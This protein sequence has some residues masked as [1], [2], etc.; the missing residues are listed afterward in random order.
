MS[1]ALC[2]GFLLAAVAFWFYRRSERQ[3]EESR[4]L[5][6]ELKAALRERDAEQ[7]FNYNV[8]QPKLEEQRRHIEKIE[9][10]NERLNEVL[11]HRDKRIEELENENKK[12]DG[13]L[14]E[15]KQNFRRY[16]LAEQNRQPAPVSL[17]TPTSA[18]RGL[19]GILGLASTPNAASP[20]Y[21][22]PAGSAA[23]VLRT[24]VFTFG[25]LSSPSTQGAQVEDDEASFSRAGPQGGHGGQ[26]SE[27]LQQAR[28]DVTQ[29]EAEAVGLREE[30][31]Q[32]LQAAAGHE[33]EVYNIREELQ[34]AR[35]AAAGIETELR[36]AQQAVMGLE[37]ERTNF[38]GK[39]RHAQ[40]AVAGYEA[41]TKNL[42]EELQHAQDTVAQLEA[43]AKSLREELQQARRNTSQ[44]EAEVLDLQQQLEAAVQQAK[45][46]TW[47]AEQV[48]EVVETAAAAI[49]EAEGAKEDLVDHKMS[50]ELQELH[51]QCVQLKVLYRGAATDV[52]SLALGGPFSSTCAHLFAQAARWQIIGGRRY[53]FPPSDASCFVHGVVSAKVE[54]LSTRNKSLQQDAKAARAEAEDLSQRN[55]SLQCHVEEVLA[56]AEDM[57]QRNK[58]LQK[59]AEKAQ[60]SIVRMLY[61][62]ID[63]DQ[64]L[65]AC[66][67]QQSEL[68]CLRSQLV[69]SRTEKESAAQVLQLTADQVD[70]ERER[71]CSLSAD[72]ERAK[73][74]VESIHQRMSTLESGWLFSGLGGSF[75]EVLRFLEQLEDFVVERNDR[76]VAL[77]A[78]AAELSQ[79]FDK[80]AEECSRLGQ[81]AA[82]LAA[83]RSA[84]L[85]DA[86]RLTGL[87]KELEAERMAAISA[88]EATRLERDDLA[89]VRESL[90]R[91]VADLQLHCESAGDEIA[92]AESRVAQLQEQLAAVESRAA[93]LQ[94]KLEASDSRCAELSGQVRQ[95]LE[96]PEEVDAVMVGLMNEVERDAEMHALSQE[97]DELRGALEAANA[98]K[99]RLQ[100]QV[101]DA[102]TQSWT[103]V[104]APPPDGSDL[105]E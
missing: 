95:L 74:V 90:S 24:P 26:S 27:L 45:S 15:K 1:A 94:A 65:E 63:R 40:Q 82:E 11:T 89:R 100:G 22:L 19:T 47:A 79:D 35:Q 9:R 105:N 97:A 2:A 53:F 61:E 20:G 54:E 75:E 51:E 46:A 43:D 28:P 16:M 92:A 5:Q 18:T 39:L 13:L 66:A 3:A 36:Q 68:D 29:L 88:L 56:E 31:Q 71:A 7:H 50:L 25:S 104:V 96:A 6:S 87:C 21:R 64:L 12:L 67:K 30:L 91:K 103:L 17:L 98:E 52:V 70:C 41:E 86:V 8:T 81:R 69:T 58:N 37:A 34:Q 44:L 32:A 93:Q 72:M 55:R 76:C 62:G 23:K 48:A 33:A 78:Q 101:A 80:V 60:A 57:S 84:L 49:Q 83:K 59:D 99:E 10:I 73:Q 4:R 102:N 85:S 42:R 14:R 77:E 38:R